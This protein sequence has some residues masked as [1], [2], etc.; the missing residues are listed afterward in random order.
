MSESSTTPI[1][2][3]ETTSRPLVSIVV[4]T[5]GRRLGFL[6]EAVASI[7]AQAYR[8]LEIVVVEDGTRHAGDWLAGQQKQLA[9]RAI[10]LAADQRAAQA[11]TLHYLPIKQGGRCRAGN[12]GLSAATGKFCGFLD[13]DD[14]F[15]PQHVETL[16]R[17]LQHNTQLVAAYAV[18]LEVPTRV[19]SLSPLAYE[20]LG[21]YASRAQPFS[22]E[23]LARRNFM[24]IQTVL[25]RRALFTQLGG[26]DEQLDALEDW[27][28]WRRYA[29]AGPFEL[30]NEVTSVYRVPGDAEAARRRQLI[31]R[32]Y[33]GIMERIW[34]I[35]PARN[36]VGAGPQTKP[37]AVGP[38][39][40]P[41]LVRPPAF[42]RMRRGAR[43]FLLKHPRLFA[44]WW[45]AR[46]L[47][48]RQ[49]RS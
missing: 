39:I 17:K 29:A 34:R 47:L 2:T 21:R 44:A 46:L 5:H 30:V 45:R 22:A 36:D 4:R 23:L 15:L 10:T 1:A 19:V 37:A 40:V 41:S 35:D 24:P 38:A 49:A 43:D 3:S 33:Q 8:P 20:E 32:D 27:D 6:R 14:L 9:A 16:V 48:K 12:A 11:V 26:L 31:F 13:D 18:A 28:L 42:L 25:F 7:L